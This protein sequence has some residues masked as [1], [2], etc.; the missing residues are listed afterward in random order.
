MI[1]ESG[2]ENEENIGKG[3]LPE[4]ILFSYNVG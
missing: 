2:I 4:A 1:C 3:Q